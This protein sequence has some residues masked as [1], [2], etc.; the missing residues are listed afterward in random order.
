MSV[1]KNGSFDFLS[2]LGLIVHVIDWGQK[3]KFAHVHIWKRQRHHHDFFFFFC[4]WRGGEGGGGG[5][6]SWFAVTDVWI[7]SYMYS[8][9][10]HAL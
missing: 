9:V 2:L 10:I 6:Q 3:F 4:G 5:G 1:L 7:M 8:T